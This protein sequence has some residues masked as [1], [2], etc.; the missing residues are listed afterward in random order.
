MPLG[1]RFPGA[2]AVTAWGNNTSSQ[3]LPEGA[4]ALVEPNL[5]QKSCQL[6]QCSAPKRSGKT[7]LIWLHPENLQRLWPAGR[8]QKI[9]WQQCPLHAKATTCLSRENTGVWAP[10][11][12]AV[13]IP[14]REPL[15]PT[16]CWSDALA[17]P[18]DFTE[19][20]ASRAASEKLLAAAPTSCKGSDLLEQGQLRKTQASQLHPKNQQ[21]HMPVQQHPFPWEGRQCLLSEEAVCCP[22]SEKHKIQDTCQWFYEGSHQWHSFHNKGDKGGSLT[23]IPIH[24]ATDSTST[25]SK[26]GRGLPET[27]ILQ[28]QREPASNK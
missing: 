15:E 20:H 8:C 13:P 18:W 6:W 26:A 19:V 3:F 9:R 27:H 14:V 11:R 17:P 24:G 22:T 2:G 16:P 5:H 1:Y 10:P 23:H 25:S 28:L 7:Q 4:P 21:R 12:E